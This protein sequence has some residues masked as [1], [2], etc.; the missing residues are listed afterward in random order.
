M[1]KVKILAIKFK[2][3]G[4]V[5]VGVPALRALRERWPNA[6]L[7]VLVAEDAVPLIQHI[8]WIN[9][10]YGLPR[11]RGKIRLRQSLP[12]LWMLRRERYA[13]S[14]DF[15]G[16]DRGAIISR[17]V[18][19]T[20]RVGPLAPKGF[21]GRDRCYTDAV[22]EARPYETHESE[23]DLHVLSALNVPPP[24]SM[25]PE[26]YAD[27][28]LLPWA[29]EIMGKDSILCHLTTS[30]V[31]KEWPVSHWSDLLNKA[32]PELSRR[33]IFLAGPSPREQE[34]LLQFRKSRPEARIQREVPTLG[35][36]MAL[37]NQARAVVCGDSVPAHIAAGL[38]V[39]GVVLFGPSP[40]R[41][42]HPH[43]KNMIVLQPKGYDR[44]GHPEEW[45][46][47]PPPISELSPQKVYECL[48]EVLKTEDVK[49]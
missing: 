48:M 32:G 13:I 28:N 45:E 16:N 35:H 44:P 33:M 9:R 7:D 15:V 2:Y 3:L 34:S 36:L 6:Q 21:R 37:I 19:A 46:E 26:L 39:P 18:R 29:S 24:A 14:V 47:P 25:D 1:S 41:Q 20:T 27:P 17:F 8:P 31:S 38:E 43:G 23:R 49:A 40:V 42:W 4:D 22:P 5:A 30:R 11:A 10:V 12:L